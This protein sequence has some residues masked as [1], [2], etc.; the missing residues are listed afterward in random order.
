VRSEQ[1]T[2][3]T[4]LPPAIAIKVVPLNDLDALASAERNLI[5]VLWDEVVSSIDVFY[6]GRC[7]VW[8]R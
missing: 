1:A 2:E 6:H 7:T 4:H 3:R 8:W 5:F